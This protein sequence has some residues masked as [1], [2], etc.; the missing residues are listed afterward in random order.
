MQLNVTCSNNKFVSDID[1]SSLV[2]ARNSAA[3]ILRA[4]TKEE[5]S[6]S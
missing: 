1:I 5:I 3:G 6:M 2:A 4:A